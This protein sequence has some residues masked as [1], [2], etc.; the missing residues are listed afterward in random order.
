MRAMSQRAIR[1]SRKH[2]SFPRRSL[3]HSNLRAEHW[4]Y[5]LWDSTAPIPAVSRCVANGRLI[6]DSSSPATGM[7]VLELHRQHKQC[8][9]D[10]LGH[11]Q[12]HCDDGGGL[13]ATP[14]RDCECLDCCQCG[15]GSTHHPHVVQD[16]CLDVRK[17]GQL[18]CLHRT[19]CIIRDGREGR[20]TSLHFGQVRIAWLS[21]C[22]HPIDTNS[23]LVN[24]FTK[25]TA[26]T[27][28]FVPLRIASFKESST[29]NLLHR[30]AT[31]HHADRTRSSGYLLLENF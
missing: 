26:G 22:D 24:R 6:A 17:L 5:V 9:T 4:S 3:S 13:Y 19:T 15:R 20:V 14:G 10:R 28:M 11:S 31:F 25:N 18:V 30:V 29:A 23:I 16:Q 2:S 7:Q 21:L 1:N 8:L 27:W 12:S